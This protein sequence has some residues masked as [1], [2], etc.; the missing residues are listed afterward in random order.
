MTTFRPIVFFNKFPD[1]A[2][3]EVESDSEVS[4]ITSEAKKNKDMVECFFELLY[5]LNKCKDTTD[6]KT[7]IET[8]D[9]TPIFEKQLRIV[10]MSIHMYDVYKE[11]HHNYRTDDIWNEII[12]S[13]ENEDNGW[14]TA[15]TFRGGMTE[16]E[17][18][19]RVEEEVNEKIDEEVEERVEEEVKERLEEKVEEK[20][21][22]L[23]TDGK[24]TMIEQKKL[25]NNIS[26]NIEYVDENDDKT[27]DSEIFGKVLSDDD[28]LTSQ[29]CFLTYPGKLN[30]ENITSFLETL[31][32][33]SYNT[34][35][36][37]DTGRN[38]KILT[39]VYADLRPNKNRT[40]PLS[41]STSSIPSSPSSLSSTS[42]ISANN[43]EN[44]NVTAN[45]K[46]PRASK[47]TAKGKTIQTIFNF[48][49]RHPL[50]RLVNRV[51]IERCVKD[52]LEKLNTKTATH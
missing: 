9:T 38:E 16:E 28:T 12:K 4:T 22:Q 40:I 21:K 39:R 15:D 27:L 29:R 46:R 2:K 18:N 24:I 17:I 3:I 45:N 52:Y 11:C 14:V 20:I 36:A 47:V 32:F 31:G 30:K 48:E 43:I 51:V 41:P 6:V 49:K 42:T 50:V 25:Y 44:K 1:D 37:Y 7:F 8:L 26:S 23:I 5:K 19:E 10:W 13:E 33:P 34:I 35:V